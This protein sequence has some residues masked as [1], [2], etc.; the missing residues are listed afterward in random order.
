MLSHIFISPSNRQKS[1][2]LNDLDYVEKQFW[3]DLPNKTGKKKVVATYG[4]GVDGSLTDIDVKEW[5]CRELPTILKY[6][7]E[8]E[9]KIID[10]VNTPFLYYGSSNSCFPVHTEDYDLYSL[11]FNHFGAAKFWYAIKPSDAGRFELAA[12]ESLGSDFLCPG[13]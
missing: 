2:N 6:V 4:A 12:R 13:F 7:K 3:N 10:G 1:V 8:D 9:G 5:N 11:N